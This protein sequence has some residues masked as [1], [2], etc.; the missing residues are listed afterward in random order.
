M[1]ILT[2]LSESSSPF[3]F[4]PHC[5]PCPP[6]LFHRHSPLPGASRGQI[7]GCAAIYGTVNQMRSRAVIFLSPGGLPRVGSEMWWSSS[8]TSSAFSRKGP[9]SPFVCGCV[10]V[11]ES[12]G[13]T[14]PLKVTCRRGSAHSLLSTPKL[15]WLTTQ[16]RCL[17]RFLSEGWKF[18]SVLLVQVLSRIWRKSL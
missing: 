3:P 1:G 12:M 17:W 11:G 6:C 7:W 14:Q 4:C 16:F 5:P 2:E 10:Y 15:C 18:A 8:F 13:S 9:G